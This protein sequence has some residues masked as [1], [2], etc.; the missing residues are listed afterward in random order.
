LE[1]NNL[2]CSEAE[3][4]SSDKTTGIRHRWWYQTLLVYS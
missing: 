4:H 1:T 3:K 2:S